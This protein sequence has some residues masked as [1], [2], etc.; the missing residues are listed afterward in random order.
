MFEEAL[1][2]HEIDIVSAPV[3]SLERKRNL[4]AGLHWASDA[5]QR[6]DDQVRQAIVQFRRRKAEEKLSISDDERPHEIQRQI[7]RAAIYRAGGW[8]AIFAEILI[9]TVAILLVMSLFGFSPLVWSIPALLVATVV[10]LLIARPI[11]AAILILAER[12]GDPLESRARVRKWFIRPAFLLVVLTVVAYI[13]MQRLDAETLLA[14]Q[15]ILS[16]LLF[17]GMLGFVF[18]GAALLVVTALLLWSR[19]AAAHYEELLTQRQ[20]IASKRDQWQ[21]EY[22][23]FEVESGAHLAPTDAVSPPVEVPAEVPSNGQPSDGKSITA[24]AGAKVGVVLLAAAALFG[25]SGCVATPTLKAEPAAER[26]SLDYV[27]DA[28]GVL[29]PPALQQA[30]QNLLKSTELIVEQNHV[31]DLRVDWFGPN[32]WLAQERL[33]LQLP[34]PTHIVIGK[35]GPSEIGKLRPDVEEA[36]KN[37]DQKAVA[38]AMVTAR[39]KYVAEMKKN[40]APLSLETLIPAPEVQSNCTD[41]NGALARFRSRT[42]A[43]RQVV[44]IVTDGRQNCGTHEIKPVTWQKG[45]AIVIVVVP[46]TEYDGR[47]DFETRRDKFAAACPWCVIV[48]FYREDMDAVVTEAVR[49]SDDYAAKK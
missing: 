4:V 15:P 47:D 14:L 33:Y 16:G 42:S 32:G 34:T 27:V 26:V 31:T 17:V 6:L 28:S 25:S 49:T 10:T 48:P 7:R 12:V 20:R 5:V 38:D 23:G 13:A 41:I 29:N 2:K 1:Q 30:G 44:T 8:S 18:L 37:R 43:A 40:L 46:G 24:L 11:H 39:A 35:P 36:G 19:P 3:K 9:A 22:N 21:H 45:V